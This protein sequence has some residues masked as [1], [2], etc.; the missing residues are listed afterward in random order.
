MAEFKV[1]FKSTGSLLGLPWLIALSGAVLLSGAAAASQPVDGANF[2]IAGKTSCALQKFTGLTWFTDR[3]LSAGGGITARIVLGGSPRC[4]VRSYSLT[5][6]L[7]GKFK[8][9]EVRLKN[10][11]Y[12]ELPLPDLKLSTSTP[13]HIGRKFAVVT[14]VMVQVSGEASEAQISGALQSPKISSQ[15]NFLRLD[16][17]G[18]GDQHLQVVDP[19]I[20]IAS[21][22]IHIATNL[23]TA[24]AA[25]ETGI[26][27]DI[28]AKPILK[29]ERFIVLEE[30][31]VDSKDIVEPKKFSKFAED[32]LNPLIDF[33]RFDRTTRAF[34]MTELYTNEHKVRFAGKL[35]LAP[36]A[37]PPTADP[38]KKSRKK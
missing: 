7:A 16:L 9:V 13:L 38:V 8:F 14:P 37:V 19:H 21:G 23:I 12:K 24:G 26:K 35:L 15:L 22:K 25:P 2:R 28:L 29:N 4:K 36:K 18:L 5:D 30:T 11:H 33:G 6:A 10:C 34:R 3:V 32:L 20:E 27:L 17:P 31:Q 1:T